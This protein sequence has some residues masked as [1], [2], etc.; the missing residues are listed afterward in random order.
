MN[1]KNPSTRAEIAQCARSFA[2]GDLALSWLPAILAGHGINPAKGILAA[3]AEMPS[4][5]GGRL[6]SGTWL[7]TSREFWSFHV[8]VPASG[9]K[10]PVVEVFEERSVSVFR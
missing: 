9:G 7:T 4:Y 1:E 3:Y 5:Q 10:P 8:L 2:D 6:C